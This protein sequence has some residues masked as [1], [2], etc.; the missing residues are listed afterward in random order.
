MPELFF[1]S[2]QLNT[3]ALSMFLGGALSTA[4]PNVQSIF[5][6]DPVG[7]FDDLNVLSFIDVLRTIITET[8]WQIVIS[9]HEESF[10]EL[11]KVKLS[12]RY[13]NCLLYTSPSPRD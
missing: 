4:N 1:S 8:G 5:I 2:A 9:T 6:D 12:P 13:Y 3:V 11:M 10:Y 7:H